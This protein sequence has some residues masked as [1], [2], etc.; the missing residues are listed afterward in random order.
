MAEVKWLKLEPGSRAFFEATGCLVVDSQGAEHLVGL[1][2]RES[3]W[4]LKYARSRW[5][6]REIRQTRTDKER[7]RYMTLHVKYQHARF[8]AIA[9]QRGLLQSSNGDDHLSGVV[10]HRR[11]TGQASRAV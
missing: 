6:P 11:S 3:T 7:K 2:V 8:R 5:W 10:R 4:Y 9:V 1:T